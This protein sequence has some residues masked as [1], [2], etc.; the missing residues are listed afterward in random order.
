MFDN[1]KEKLQN[2]DEENLVEEDLDEDYIDEDENFRFGP[3][4]FDEEDDVILPDTYFG[5][6][7]YIFYIL[8]DIIQN[9]DNRKL[10]FDYLLR[11]IRIHKR[12]MQVK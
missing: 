5:E 8:R 12:W 4:D 11:Q 9:S 7:I 2:T 1:N 3:E 6:L 10:K